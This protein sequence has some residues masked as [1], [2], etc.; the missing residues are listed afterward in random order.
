[1]FMRDT[2]IRAVKLRDLPLIRRLIENGCV[3][4]SELGLTRDVMGTGGV[5]LSGVLLPQRGSQTLL[6]RA[7][8]QSVVGQFRIRPEDTT[9]QI[10][11]IAP[12]LE[13]EAGDTAW[14]YMLDA[15]AQEAGKRSAHTLVAEV[16]EASALFETMRIA[17]FAVYARQEIW[18]RE[19]GQFA[20]PEQSVHLEPATDADLPAI[21][22]LYS[23]TTPQLVQHIA[24]LNG[25]G[26]VYRH[27]G[28]IE[29]YI[30]VSEGKLGVY[31]MPCLHPETSARAADIIITAARAARSDKL[32]VYVRVRRYQE[33]M[34]DTISRLGFELWG[35]QAVMVRHIA[36]GVRYAPFAP[37]RQTLEAIP[38][39]AGR[40]T[41]SIIDVSKQE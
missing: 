16:D 11:F 31:L 28:R 14:L 3:L 32:P 35:Q 4:N 24:D 34:D 29:G 37:L 23:R 15:L 10:V 38:A 18:R 26:Y 25:Q 12:R 13:P 2:D 1:M 36:A 40:A 6:V 33:W 21:Q 8:D 17:G 30:A 7:E 5:T 19:S 22:S 9:A 20:A 41:E 27:N 39:S